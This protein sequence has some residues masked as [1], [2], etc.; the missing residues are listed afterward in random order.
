MLW[1]MAVVTE[2]AA[3]R[4]ILTEAKTIAVLGAHPNPTKA[5]HYVPGYLARVGYTLYP[6]N[7]VYVGI[8][9][10]G[11]AVL[12]QLHDVPVPIDIVNV[13]R[14]SSH[15]PAHLEELLRLTPLPRVV[16][17]QTGIS[18]AAVAS[19]LIAAGIQVVQDRCILADHRQLL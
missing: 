4:R 6:V 16:W 14:R 9:L 2:P 18:D 15:L 1:R 12:A 10:F 11:H 5:A 17:F 13:F 8:T 7:P 19:A 3:L